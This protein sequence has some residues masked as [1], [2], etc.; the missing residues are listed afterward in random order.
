MPVARWLGS[1]LVE[2]GSYDA[3]SDHALQPGDAWPAA[4]WGRAGIA[5]RATV[6]QWPD[7][8][9]YRHLE[10]FL[11]DPT[12]LSQRATAGFLRRAETSSL[13]F[14]DG[15]LEDVRNHLKW[16]ADCGFERVA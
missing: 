3:A 5:H 8:R 12:P 14:A 9:P 11:R 15:F 2:P 1:Q 16:I 7:R 6:G 4:A 10:G 13:R